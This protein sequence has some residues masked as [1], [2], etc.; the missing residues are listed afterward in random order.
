MN[1]DNLNNNSQVLKMSETRVLLI[2]GYLSGCSSGSEIFEFG[3]P[4]TREGPALHKS[5]GKLLTAV[6]ISGSKALIYGGKTCG[7]DLETD[8][9][10]LIDLDLN[11]TTLVAASTVNGPRY[12]VLAIRT[13]TPV[14]F[15]NI[16]LTASDCLEKNADSPSPCG[17]KLC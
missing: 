14:L 2:S 4:A 5:I 15:K 11:V 17:M 9:T 1:C 3:F 16:D 12:V 6:A 10:Y 13:V 7:S 8:E